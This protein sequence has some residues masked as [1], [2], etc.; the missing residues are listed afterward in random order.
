VDTNV[1]AILYL[2][3]VPAC[4]ELNMR[5]SVVEPSGGV[6]SYAPP[7][8]CLEGRHLFTIN[9]SVTGNYRVSAFYANLRA[10]CTITS[11]YPAPTAFPELHPLLA[12]A[13]ALGAIALLRRKRV[14]R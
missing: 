13:A 9:T 7:V 10:N 4:D 12:V 14:R 5:L 3:Y 6:R 8:S 1:F 2:S 11:F